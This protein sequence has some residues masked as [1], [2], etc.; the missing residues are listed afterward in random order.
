MADVERCGTGNLVKVAQS[1]SRSITTTTTNTNTTTTTTSTTTTPSA[2]ATVAADRD[3]I[4]GEVRQDPGF[5]ALNR[6]VRGAICGTIYSSRCPPV[7][8]AVLGEGQV[9]CRPKVTR[10]DV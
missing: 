4:L 8:S 7:V 10:C 3:R 9:C 1:V 6:I 2:E 5:G